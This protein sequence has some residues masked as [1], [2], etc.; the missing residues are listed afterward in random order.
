ME[1]RGEK[2]RCSRAHARLAGIGESAAREHAL[3]KRKVAIG[4]AA[5]S[6]LVVSDPTVSRRHAVISRRFSRYRVT[7]LNSANGTFLNNR[8]VSGPAPIAKGDELRFGA[9]RFVFLD[10]PGA[11]KRKARRA[12]LRNALSMFLLLMAAGFGLTEYLLNR[13]TDTAPAKAAY[14]EHQRGQP[15]E[16][17]TPLA[18]VTPAPAKD[19]VARPA[20]PTVPISAA[21]AAALA[22]PAPASPAPAWLERVNYWRTLAKVPP[23]TEDFD[24][25][26]GLTA[27]ARYLIVNRKALAVGG[28]MHTEDPKLP[29]FSPEGLA[30]A[31]HG[32]GDVSPPGALAPK[33]DASYID[34]WVNAPLHRT[35]IIDRHLVRI[36]LGR[37]C[38]H[39]VCAAAL[40]CDFGP[41]WTASDV[42]DFPEPVEFPPDG[43]T[44]PAALG[45]FFG[46][47]PNPLSGCPGYGL[48]TGEPI[49]LQFD[50]RFSP[51]L[52]G[53]TVTRN[54]IQVETCGIDSASYV[55]ESESVQN[56]GRANMWDSILLIPREPLTPGAV[57]TV[58]VAVEGGPPINPGMPLWRFVGQ[59][60]T[61]SWSFSVGR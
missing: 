5:D 35:P 41:S 29:G 20:N 40:S 49:T 54:G 56:I 28:A 55:N 57:Y 59:T 45:T 52:T 48:P 14:L 39:G 11:E 33:S 1:W 46:E 36:A 19:V 43:A 22:S 34:A 58:T 17:A 18:L 3:K 6:D 51:K 9:A 25:I 32:V 50:S 42:K 8:R 2:R 21:S 4:S 23:V 15:R 31:Q 26:P 7:D 60:R 24:L 53:F 13:I 47:W 37:Y 38:Q 16:I 44:L 30:A 27:H 10:A 12:A 61:Y